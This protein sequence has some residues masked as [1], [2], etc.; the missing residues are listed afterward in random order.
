LYAN[1]GENR[2]CLC[3]EP[4]EIKQAR[5]KGE[6]DIGV[7]F[8]ASLEDRLCSW[9][10]MSPMVRQAHHKDEP[11]ENSQPYPEL[12]EG[13]SRDFMLFLEPSKGTARVTAQDRKFAFI[14]RRISSRLS[15]VDANAPGSGAE[16]I[17]CKSFRLFH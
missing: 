2:E 5:L 11:I 10:P 15:A 14:Y 8:G 12:V 7:V 13:W 3:S 16:A 9:K 6:Y 1:F 17:R 4:P